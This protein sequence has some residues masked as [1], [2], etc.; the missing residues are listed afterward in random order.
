[1][2]VSS[3]LH[4]SMGIF[5]I[6]FLYQSDNVSYLTKLSSSSMLTSSGHGDSSTHT[7]RIRLP[8]FG[9]MRRVNL[10]L[11]T[12]KRKYVVQMC[13]VAA[14]ISTAFC[15]LTRLKQYAM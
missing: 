1:M 4:L 9:V 8:S 14:K 13:F 6:I 12:P 10:P 5:G 2:P 15:Q 3:S 11:N 7:R